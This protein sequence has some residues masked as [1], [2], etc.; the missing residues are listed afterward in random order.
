VTTARAI[1]A[2]LDVEF[3]P[4]ADLAGGI[5]PGEVGQ[6]LRTSVAKHTW[7]GA[8]GAGMMVVDEPSGCL[9]VL[10]S[11][12]VQA[13]LGRVLEGLRADPQRKSAANP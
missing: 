11:Q 4:A 1:A 9:I 8:G 2:R 5:G 12:P 10:Q 13:A 7:S 6:R 3:Y